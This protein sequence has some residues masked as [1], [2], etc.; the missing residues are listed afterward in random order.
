MKPKNKF[1]YKDDSNFLYLES[2][3]SIDYGDI[4]YYYNFDLKYLYIVFKDSSYTFYLINHKCSCNSPS[5]LKYGL[6]LLKNDL[7]FL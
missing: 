6:N 2:F 5:Y 3:N 7:I 4:D 1:R